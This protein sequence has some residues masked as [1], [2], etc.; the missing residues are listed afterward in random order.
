MDFILDGTVVEGLQKIHEH[1]FRV[2]L[3]I[4]GD[5]VRCMFLKFGISHLFFS[6]AAM[7]IIKIRHVPAI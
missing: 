5:N 4:D 6:R 7:L 1:L 2:Q 3:K